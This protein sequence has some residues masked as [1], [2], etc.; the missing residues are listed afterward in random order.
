M[1]TIG[2]QRRTWICALCIALA[3]CGGGG[4]DGGDGGAAGGAGAAGGG[5]GGGAGGPGAQALQQEID[6]LFPFTPDRPFDV[7]MVCG[8]ANSQ[9]TY[10]FDFDEDGSLRVQVRLDTGQ[11]LGFAGTYTYA[12]GA[13]RMVA[14]DNPILPLDETTTR[15]VAHLG[16]PG[17]L[18]TPSMRCGAYGHGYNPPATETFSSFDCPLI[19]IQAVTDED[20]SIEFVANALPSGQTVPGSVFRQR[21]IQVSGQQNPNVTRAN[22]IYRRVGDTFYADFGNQFPDVNLLKGRFL[23]GD[24]S[25]EVEQLEPAAG[26]CRRR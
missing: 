3:G 8:R 17:E 1:K 13:I 20:N 26:P 4:G 14:L 18:D 22:G 15:I 5:A 11:V 2:L 25:I 19:R 24:Q 23:A 9:L 10:F 16:L 12:G 6:R 21:D 7:T